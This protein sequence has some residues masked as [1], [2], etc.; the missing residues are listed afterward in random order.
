MSKV[1]EWMKE[2][3]DN[4][5]IGFYATVDEHGAPCVSPKGTSV[6]LDDDTIAFGNIR[7]P[8]TVANIMA[9]PKIEVNFVDVLTRR[10]FRA[11]G[12]A[13]YVDRSSSE[14]DSL[15]S[16]FQKWDMLTKRFKGIVVLKIVK[17]TEIESPVY[18]IGANEGEL[19]EQ[20]KQHY[21][22]K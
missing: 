11:R 9:N 15:I 17:A 7:S 14:F 12:N 19:K 2:V 3:V 18:D 20:W 21:M 1:T 8:N 6:V 4:N 13:Y 22:S 16:S 10:G 5:S